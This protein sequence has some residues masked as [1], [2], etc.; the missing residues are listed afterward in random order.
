MARVTVHFKSTEENFAPEADGRKPNT[1]RKIDFSERKFQQ[2]AAMMVTSYGDVEITETR[3]GVP[4]GRTF[5][6]RITHLC[7]FGE[8]LIISWK[9]EPQPKKFW[10]EKFLK[11]RHK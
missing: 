10:S 7:P 5:T 11:A 6:R 8:W 1:V 3:G 9:H 2:L 4:T